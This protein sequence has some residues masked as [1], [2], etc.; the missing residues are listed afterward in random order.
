VVNA[1]AAVVTTVSRISGLNSVDLS[2]RVATRLARPV[3]TPVVVAPA[4][5]PSLISLASAAAAALGRPLVITPGAAVS[6]PTVAGYLSAAKP[7][8][9][10][11]VGSA[12]D[13][14]DS[15][16]TSVAP[17]SRAAGATPADVSSALAR[18]VGVGLTAQRLSISSASRLTMT[19]VSNPRTPILVVSGTL[20]PNATAVLQAG[21]AA[22]TVSPDLTAAVVTAARRA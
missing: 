1:T 4:T 11:V 7:A 17:L 13:V 21:V 15:V 10:L 14:A 6:S 20:S 2:V 16:F 12:A 5:N 22:I 9:L 3:G 18:F 8:S 19:L